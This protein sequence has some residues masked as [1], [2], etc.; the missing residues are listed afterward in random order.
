MGAIG[1]NVQ[2]HLPTTVNEGFK[3]P[4]HMIIGNKI[5]QEVK[6]TSVWQSDRS[7]RLESIINFRSYFDPHVQVTVYLGNGFDKFK[8]K[9]Y[10]IYR[11]T[12]SPTQF[13][14]IHDSIKQIIMR[15]LIERLMKTG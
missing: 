9:L 13:Y 8:Q 1:W 5:D 7:T 4:P 10:D 12:D 15:D 11:T 14:S 3:S 6:H 2:R